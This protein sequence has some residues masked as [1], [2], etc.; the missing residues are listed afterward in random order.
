MIPN[1]LPN[2][3]GQELSGG[4]VTNTNTVGAWCFQL[5]ETDDFEA[6]Y[7]EENHPDKCLLE[8]TWEHLQDD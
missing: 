3:H 2:P 6:I 8:H 7:M 1:G 4:R 5:R